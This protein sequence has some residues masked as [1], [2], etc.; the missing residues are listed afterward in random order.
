MMRRILLLSIALLVGGC[1][2][3]D[4]NAVS[5]EQ[6][7]AAWPFTLKSGRVKCMFGQYAVLEGDD[8]FLYALNGA[9]KTA[10]RTGEQPFRDVAQIVRPGGNYTAVLNRATALCK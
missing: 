1:A 9:A 6:M 8:G 7:G 3:D 2:T 4:P 10:A 5:E